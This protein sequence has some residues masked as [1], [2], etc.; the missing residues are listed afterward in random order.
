LSFEWPSITSQQSDQQPAPAA[1]L[2]RLVFNQVLSLA[3][4]VVHWRPPPAA[5]AAAAALLASEAHQAGS[6]ISSASGGMKAVFGAGG[7]HSY[8]P[9]LGLPALVEALKQ[10]LQTRN[11]LTG[12]R[13]MICY[14]CYLL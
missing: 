7:V 6:G 14:N 12:V 5:T 10:K 4:G 11:G 1:S 8:G 3:Q 9:A 13:Y 2:C